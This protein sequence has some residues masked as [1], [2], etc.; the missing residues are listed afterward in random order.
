[1]LHR[2]VDPDDVVQH[3]AEGQVAVALI[4]VGEG[5]VGHVPQV[6]ALHDVGRGVVR[7]GVGRPGGHGH[8]RRGAGGGGGD[9]RQRRIGE[10]AGEVLA[11]VGH[12]AP[13]LRIE[14]DDVEPVAIGKRLPRGADAVQAPEVVLEPAH[15]EGGVPHVVEEIVG[16]G[17]VVHGAEVERHLVLGQLARHVVLDGL[18]RVVH[19]EVAE[20]VGQLLRVQRPQPAPVAAR[21]I[22]DQRRLRGVRGRGR[23]RERAG[24]EEQPQAARHQ[25]PTPHARLPLQVGPRP[26]MMR[27][28]ICST[29]RAAHPPADAA[30]RGRT[31]RP[32][33]GILLVCA[34]HGLSARAVRGVDRKPESC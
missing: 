6:A 31:G 15:R 19:G 21:V 8:R 30:T 33:C 28:Q 3:I 1:M 26:P 13:A 7:R 25:P 22:E 27:H 11:P 5:D 32:G 34:G 4:H 10:V 18:Q 2:V 9:D 12:A 29:A 16:E 17:V 14:V 20:E 23:R 24:R